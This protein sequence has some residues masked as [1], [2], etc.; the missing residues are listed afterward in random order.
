MVV[1]PR[2]FPSIF[3]VPDRTFQKLP[4][5]TFAIEEHQRI[6]F[7]LGTFSYGFWSSKLWK[8]WSGLKPHNPPNTMWHFMHFRNILWRIFCGYKKV[9]CS[10]GCCSFLLR[11]PYISSRWERSAINHCEINVSLTTAEFAPRFRF[12]IFFVSRPVLINGTNI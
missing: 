9:K 5:S 10:V 7:C 4:Y 3:L 8:G 12:S 6:S 2:Q 1:S 11:S